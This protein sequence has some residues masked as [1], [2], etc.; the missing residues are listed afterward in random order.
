M[1]AWRLRTG[2]RIQDS[3]SSGKAFWPTC[4]GRGR[5]R[6]RSD[7]S[8]TLQSL[9]TVAGSILWRSF[10]AP[11]GSGI[12]R[13]YGR[14]RHGSTQGRAVRDGRDI[15]FAQPASA[16][17]KVRTDPEP[18]NAGPARHWLIFPVVSENSC[19]LKGAST[20]LVGAAQLSLP[21]ALKTI[22]CGHIQARKP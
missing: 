1:R 6:Q 17:Y 11:I 7:Y 16:D 5:R 18:A 13:R 10:A 2:R 15:T 19:H 21:K 9:C 12:E 3:P 8:P 4:R 20:G 22:I 14:Q